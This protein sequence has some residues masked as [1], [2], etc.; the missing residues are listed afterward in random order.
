MKL[1]V[2]PL[3]KQEYKNFDNDPICQNLKI[4]LE[5]DCDDMT[6]EDFFLTMIEPM[7]LSM[8]YHPNTIKNF[9]DNN[10]SGR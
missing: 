6:L 8:G 1:T 4:T 5:H 10:E 2:E 3:N 9:F 7:L